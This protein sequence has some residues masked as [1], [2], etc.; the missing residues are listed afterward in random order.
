MSN[1]LESTLEI[2]EELNEILA[3]CYD[4]EK[5]YKEAALA[6]SDTALKSM[7][8]NY[9][10]QRNEFGHQIKNEIIAMG[11][12]VKTGGT[13]AGTLHRAW[14]DFRS[15]I[16]ENDETAILKEAIRGENAALENYQ[17]AMEDL[18][19][20]SSA[21]T[22]LVKQRNQIRTALNRLEQLVPVFDEA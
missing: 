5:G 11:G 3:K 17:D 12:Q 18:P 22:T 2:I 19:V 1:K 7:F 8:Q 13:F 16:T 14:M 4:A 21:Y 20:M 10:T 6:V 15:S 9:V